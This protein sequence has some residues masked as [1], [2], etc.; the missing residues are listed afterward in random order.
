MGPHPTE[1]KPGMIS[2]IAGRSIRLTGLLVGLL[3]FLK[4]LILSRLMV[5]WVIFQ[6]ANSQYI[7][8][9]IS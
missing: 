2:V 3:Y 5:L 4:N 9:S 7:K 1:P 6:V 8:Y